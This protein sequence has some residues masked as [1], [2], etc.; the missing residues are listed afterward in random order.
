MHIETMRLTH[1][2]CEGYA[3]NIDGKPVFE[4]YTQYNAPNVA[5]LNCDHMDVLLVGHLLY[6]AY[7]AGMNTNGMG[8]VTIRKR[9]TEDYERYFQFTEGE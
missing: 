5:R 7:K 9:E 4:Y 1:P 3:V 8:E 2:D 6:D